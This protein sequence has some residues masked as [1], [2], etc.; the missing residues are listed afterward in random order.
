MEG[1]AVEHGFLENLCLP[2]SHSLESY[3]RNIN[4][5]DYPVNDSS[6]FSGFYIA[7]CAS[8]HI[9]DPKDWAHIQLRD[10]TL[11]QVIRLLKD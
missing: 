9:K 2:D 3:L 7:T 1:T 4:H 10:T 5:L 11:G 8:I 6:P